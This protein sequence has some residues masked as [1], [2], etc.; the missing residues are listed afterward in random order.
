MSAIVMSTSSQCNHNNNGDEADDKTISSTT[1]DDHKN[2]GA[3]FNFMDFTDTVDSLVNTRLPFFRPILNRSRQRCYESKSY[4]SQ[5]L[6]EMHRFFQSGRFCDVILNTMESP[7]SIPCHR[8]VLAAS[9]M[10]FDRMFAGNMAESHSQEIN[11]RNIN[12]S[13]LKQLIKYAY[14]SEIIIDSNTVLDMFEAAD[15]FQFAELRMFCQDFLLDEVTAQN[16]L[17]FM[18]YA[19]VFSSKSLYDRSLSVAAKKF[20]MIR[21]EKEFLLL[22]YDHVKRLLMEDNIEIDYE[23]YV[24]EAFK[25]WMAHDFENRQR[26]L[27]DLFQSIRL[28]FVSR[29]YLIEVISKDPVISTSL[30]CTAI[31]QR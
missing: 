19:D 29:W 8:L 9:S 16:C 18:L 26:Y 3:N 2:N 5:A 23:E 14:T 7:T 17:S 6:L 10:Y 25:M 21:L 24:Y 4:S 11:L 28:N 12:G 22:P 13:T 27:V 31:V 1:P 15:M 30:E 20:D